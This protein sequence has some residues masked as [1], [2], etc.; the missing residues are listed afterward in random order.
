MG[1]KYSFSNFKHRKR[2]I[3]EIFVTTI[4][5][6]KQMLI[7]VQRNVGEFG[8]TKNFTRHNAQLAKK[9]NL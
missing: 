2:T 9:I 7:Y 6:K 5:V 4:D 1:E 8:Y 3:L